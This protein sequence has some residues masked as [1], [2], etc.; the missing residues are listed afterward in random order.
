MSINTFGQRLPTQQ[1]FQN[2]IQTLTY[3]YFPQ[4]LETGVRH[5]ATLPVVG[6]YRT[7]ASEIMPFDTALNRIT[8]QEYTISGVG[9]L[10]DYDQYGYQIRRPTPYLSGTACDGHTLCVEPTCFGFTEGVVESNNLIHNLC[11]ELSMPC[12]KDKFYGN[13]DFTQQIKQWIGMFFAQPA[14]VVEAYQRTRLLRESIKI[15]ATNKTINYVGGGVT[16]TDGMSLP[17]YINPASPQAMPNLDD[18]GDGLAIGGANLDAFVTHVAPMIFADSFAGG[19]ESVTCYGQKVDYIVAKDQSMRAMDSAFMADLARARMI[20]GYNAEDPLQ[21]LLGGDNFVDDRLFPTFEKDA[22]G[23]VLP[24]E[25]ETLQAATLMGYIQTFNPRHSRAKIRGLLFVPSNWKFTLVEPPMDDFSSLGLG[26]GANFGANTPGVWPVTSSSAF[27]RNTIGPDGIVRLGQGVTG[28]EV[29]TFLVGA[30]PRKVPIREAVRTILTQTYS[31]QTCGAIDG[32]LPIIGPRTVNQQVA[33]GFALKSTIW[34]GSMVRGTARP[35]LLLFKIDNP[36]S[37]KAIEV[38]DAVEIDVAGGEQPLMLKSCCPGTEDFLL[39]KFTSPIGDAYA[40]DDHVLY[41]SGPRGNSYLATVT[42]VD[43]EGTTVH[44]TS[45]TETILPCCADVDGW[46]ALGTLINLEGVTNLTS[47]IFKAEYDSE[48]GDLLIE[49]YDPIAP[50][51]D[52]VAVTISLTNGI[53]IDAEL[54]AAADAGV[55]FSIDA[56]TVDGEAF[57]LGTLD[58]ECLQGAIFTLSEAGST[59]S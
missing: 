20:A 47:E 7:M 11:W 26:A 24:I 38:C 2:T 25:A 4:V 18:L 19:M 48:A 36:R 21:A 16:V 55:F 1:D 33:D 30:T 28:T 5:F 14:A 50:G 54:A 22:D 31:S 41:R 51:D 15:V 35:V 3:R 53:V 27:A 37:T 12:L 23:N 34:I 39:L 13:R 6:K 59:G 57:D 17:F 8:T 9:S 49:T 10:I 43:A 32:Q 42:A 58:C 40:V 45:D 56:A 46:G 29:S 44:I 52:A